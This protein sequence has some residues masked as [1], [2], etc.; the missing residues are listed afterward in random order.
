MNKTVHCLTFV[1]QTDIIPCSRRL[2]FDFQLLFG[3]GSKRFSSWNQ[4]QTGICTRREN[5][6]LEP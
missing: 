5:V 4:T 2:L 6:C 3:C 1:L